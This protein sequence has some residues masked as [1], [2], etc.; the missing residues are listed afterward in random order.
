[1]YDDPAGGPAAGACPIPDDPTS[2]RR[3]SSRARSSRH[4]RPLPERPASARSC[5]RSTTAD[6]ARPGRRVTPIRSTA[7]PPSHEPVPQSL[8]QQ[9]LVCLTSGHVNCPRYLRGSSRLAEPPVERVGRDARTVTP[10]TAGALV[11]VRRRVRAV[12]RVRGRQRRA[13]PDAPRR[14]IDRPTAR[15]SARTRRPRRAAEP[16]GRHRRD[17]ADARRRPRRPRPTAIA[18]AE[19]DAPPPRT[20]TPSPTP[21]RPRSRPRSRRRAATRC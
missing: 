6:S 12:A 20:P 19:S 18:D 15:S 2:P 7:A 9:E 14:A 11:A 21:S 17:A 16:D 10:A 5:G 1:M 13:G 8:R 3:P 4:R